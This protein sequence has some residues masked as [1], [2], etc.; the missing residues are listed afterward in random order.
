MTSYSSF[1]RSS[2]FGEMPHH[3]CLPLAIDSLLKRHILPLDIYEFA[4]D[5][6]RAGTGWNEVISKIYVD[7]FRERPPQDTAYAAISK[8]NSFGSAPNDYV[9]DYS[10][11]SQYH[12]GDES[13][14]R[15]KL[16]TYLSA[17]TLNECLILYSEVNKTEHVNAL[18][19]QPTQSGATGGPVFR[20]SEN[21]LF[22][23]EQYSLM[24]LAGVDGSQSRIP[25]FQRTYW[26]SKSWE[27][28]ILPPEPA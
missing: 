7:F 19:S 14:S 9:P 1:E 4:A 5:A 11:I 24:Q 23:V 22:C 2:E 26:P 10:A 13:I 28:I 21:G 25:Q 20:Y 18:E 12:G 16:L 15:L 17:A 3:Y 8:Y 6:S 27:L